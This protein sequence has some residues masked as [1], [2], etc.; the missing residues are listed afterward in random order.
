MTTL[1]FVYTSTR[2]VDITKTEAQAQEIASTVSGYY[3]AE[4]VTENRAK[5]LLEI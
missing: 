3:E 2:L 1:Y 4:I 5:F